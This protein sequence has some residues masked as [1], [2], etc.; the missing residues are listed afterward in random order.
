MNDS[1][2]YYIGTKILQGNKF[3]IADRL[4]YSLEDAYRC[5]TNDITD[6]REL[7]PELFY[8]P[9]LFLNVN[10]EDFGIR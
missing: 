5:A 10:H 7:V 1:H 8:M 2:L 4:F 3:D 6:V 9:E